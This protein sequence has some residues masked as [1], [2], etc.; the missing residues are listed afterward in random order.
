MKRKTSLSI[1]ILNLFVL[2]ISPSINAQLLNGNSL[3]PVQ[4]QDI[5]HQIQPGS[6]LIIGEMHGLAPVQAQQI[7][8]LK[9]LRATG[10]KLSIGFEF[11]NYTD[12]KAINNYRSN[13]ISQDEF[14]KTI[15]WGG[16]SFDFYKP[17]L[18]FPDAKLGETALGLNVPSF[19]TKQLS[20]GGYDSL[21]PEQKS[22]LPADFTL[23]NQGYKDRF[24]QAM[25]G[26]MPPEKLDLYFAS[27][28]AWDDTI[29]MNAANYIEQ[30]PQDVFVIIIGEFHVAY[31]GGTPDRLT[32]RLLAKGLQ[33]KITT[34]S[35]LYVD[36]MS[37]D[38][39]QTEI[40]PSLLYGKRS[41]FIWLST[42]VTTP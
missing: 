32:Q 17:Q 5:V 8:I 19:V 24:A 4:I 2:F 27:Q 18:L 33:P 1:L 40:T 21:T 28:S 6:I 12:Q 23:G 9:A 38:E 14:L 22:L 36:G 39:I 41:D 20:K 31:G 29:S 11:F 30:H 7:E 16:F 3:S 26:H 13:Q 37:P 35:Q 25:G 10:L 15:N 42:S 34:I